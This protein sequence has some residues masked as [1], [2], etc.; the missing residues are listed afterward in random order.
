MR[1]MFAWMVPVIAVLVALAVPSWAAGY[2]MEHYYCANDL[3]VDATCPPYGEVWDAHLDLNLAEAG[4][5]SHET[6][7]DD[8][9]E[10]SREYTPA[11]CMYYAGEVAKQESEGQFGYPRAWNAGKVT[12]YVYGEEFGYGAVV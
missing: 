5:E 8:Y 1:W 7:L 2:E 4:D 9:Y 3:A 6:C 10:K 11:H 12:H